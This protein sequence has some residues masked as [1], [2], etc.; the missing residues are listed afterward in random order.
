[1][2]EEKRILSMEFVLAEKKKYLRY[3]GIILQ[4]DGLK[5]NGN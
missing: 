5:P 1:M 4:K 2:Q 3:G